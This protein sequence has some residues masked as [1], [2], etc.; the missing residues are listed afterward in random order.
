MLPVLPFVFTASDG[1]FVG[2]GLPLLVGMALTF[3]AVATLATVGGG[4]AVHANEYGRTAALIL[5]TVFGLTILFTSLADRLTRPL[6]AL[7][8]RLSK[9]AG[10]EAGRGSGIGAALLL[11][12]ATDYR[13]RLVLG[14]FWA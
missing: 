13:G 8:S 1:P 2:S 7:G 9:L 14:Q 5:L 11:G 4:W 10:G 3:T 6:V 12:C